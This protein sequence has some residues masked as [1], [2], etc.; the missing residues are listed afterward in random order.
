[1][2]LILRGTR[3][4]NSCVV[5]FPSSSVVV[6]NGG[7]VPGPAAPTPVYVFIDSLAVSLCLYG[8]HRVSD[9]RA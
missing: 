7:V 5:P 9:A 3:R 6:W 8:V 2:L 4:A 1:M